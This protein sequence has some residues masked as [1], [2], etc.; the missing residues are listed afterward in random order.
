MDLKA[1]GKTVK[2]WF[3]RKNKT[4]EL[5]REI[6]A[7]GDGQDITKGYVGSLAYP[8]DT[9]LRDGVF[10]DVKLYEQLV[11]ALETGARVW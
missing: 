5:N 1:V 4:P 3:V 11:M 9:V 8:E 2:D 6:A 10:G 7:S